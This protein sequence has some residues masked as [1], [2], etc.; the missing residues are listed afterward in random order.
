MT[1]FN[2]LA[3]VDVLSEAYIE[4]VVASYVQFYNNQTPKH[5]AKTNLFLFSKHSFSVSFENKSVEKMGINIHKIASNDPEKVRHLFQDASILF[6]P[7]MEI[8]DTSVVELLISGV[9]ILCHK[10]SEVRKHV[11]KQYTLMA[12]S[13][14]PSIKYNANH[15]IDDYSNL[16]EML[17]FDPNV[18]SLLK[19]KA[20]K[21]Y[22]RKIN[23]GGNSI[24]VLNLV[25]EDSA[26]ME[27]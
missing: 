7:N 21:K 17:Y 10:K 4:L 6:I 3:T 13:S 15:A 22:R 8:P 27:A 23:S 9:P 24:P 18:Q 2:I 12:G 19:K 1:T 16:L 5:Q 26:R 14:D 25:I 11:D 20:I